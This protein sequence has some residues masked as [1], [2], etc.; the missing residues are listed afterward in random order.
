MTH[1]EVYTKF[2]LDDFVFIFILMWFAIPF[3]YV[4]ID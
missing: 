2:D 1:I 4:K 3:L